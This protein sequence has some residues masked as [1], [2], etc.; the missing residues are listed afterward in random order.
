M[1]D[2]VFLIPFKLAVSSLDFVM[3]IKITAVIENCP[4]KA[5]V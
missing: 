5:Y 2:E 1:V 4:E 3:M